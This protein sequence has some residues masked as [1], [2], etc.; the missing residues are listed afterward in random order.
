MDTA[1][2]HLPMLTGKVS[3]IVC[4]MILGVTSL[5][6]GCDP[7]REAY[8]DDGVEELTQEDIE[9][10]L[11]PPFRKTERVLS[12]TTIWVYRYVFLEKDL[13]PVG[14]DTLGQGITEVANAAAAL[15]GKPA[16]GPTLEKPVCLHYVLTFDQRKVLREWKRENCES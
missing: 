2:T 1:V 11:G 8:L 12:G 9:E 3:R 10:K 5:L 16:G 7:W 13:N 6:F 14:I 15:V 4:T